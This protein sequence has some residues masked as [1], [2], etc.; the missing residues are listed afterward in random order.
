MKKERPNILTLIKQNYFSIAVFVCI[1]LAEIAPWLGAR[2]GP[3]APEI[4]VKYLAVSIIFYTSGLSVKWRDLSSAAK[5]YRLHTFIQAFSFVFIPLY[6]QTFL[7]IFG[8]FVELNSWIYQGLVIVGCMPPSVSSAVILTKSIGGNEAAA[9][10]NSALGSLLGIILTPILLLINVGISST[11]PVLKIVLQ[12]SQT[13]ILPVIFGQI[14]QK[15]LSPN[16][17][18]FIP[19][20]ALGQISLLFIIY[21]SFCDMFSQDDYDIDAKVVLLT[22]LLVVVIQVTLMILIFKT[23]CLL[24][25]NANLFSPQDIIAITFCSTQKSL[26]LGLTL[27]YDSRNAITENSVQWICASL[28]DQPTSADLSSGSAHS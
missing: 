7:V 28:S 23:S 2:G 17:L 12:L 19:F 14:T 24:S 4:T 16:Q 22:V 18:S 9:I 26:T 27:P 8:L 21:S 25:S 3:L 15:F 11:L 1:I 10:F 20:S 5:Q 6:I 13:M